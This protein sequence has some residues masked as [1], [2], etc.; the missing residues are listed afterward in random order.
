MVTYGNIKT[1][2]EAYQYFTDCAVAN[3]DYFLLRKN[4]PKHETARHIE[5][6]KKM[7]AKGKIFNVDMTTYE[8]RLNDILQYSKEV[9]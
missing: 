1:L 9:E 6:C 3:L 7:I 2:K 4:P 8:I 5:L